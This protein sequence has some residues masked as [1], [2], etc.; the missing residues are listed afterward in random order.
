MADMGYTLAHGI[1]CLSLD[2]SWETL[3]FGNELFRGFFALLPQ[4][5]ISI[6]FETKD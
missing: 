1:L 4:M 3:L 2:F 5:A 6:L